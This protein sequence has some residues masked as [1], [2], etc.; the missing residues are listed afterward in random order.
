MPWSPFLEGLFKDTLMFYQDEK[1]AMFID[2]SH[3][4]S[5]SRSLG[6]DV[7]YKQMLEFFRKKTNLVRAYYYAAIVKT[8]EEY[9]PLKPLTD[10]LSYNGYALV[11]KDAKEFVDSMG[12]NRI[13]G[14]MD[15][16]IACDMLEQA[17][18]TE[19]MILFGGDGDLR[20]LVEAVQRKGVRVTVASSIKVQLISDELRR[21]A[22]HFLEIADIS[23]NFTRARTERMER[24]D[25]TA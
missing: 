2:G 12:R 4:F 19:H 11:T 15:V 3:L 17:P 9:S 22:D 7:D 1:T 13:K 21:Q 25:R 24:L 16:E 18:N 14:N 20:R 23:A 6:F 5:V 8:A 10:W